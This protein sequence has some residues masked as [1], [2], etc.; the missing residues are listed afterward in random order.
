MRGVED[1]LDLD[2][3]TTMVT[4]WANAPIFEVSKQ[5]TNVAPYIQL[6]GLIQT[7]NSGLTYTL[8]SEPVCTCAFPTMLGMPCTHFGRVLRDDAFAAFHLGLVHSQ[9]FLE[10]LH[11]HEELELMCRNVVGKL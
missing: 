1:L 6:S 11:M 8:Y 10:D 3:P 7:S 2:L 5:G 4:P 9:H